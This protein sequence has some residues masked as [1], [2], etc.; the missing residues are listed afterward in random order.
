MF[1]Q[2]I[3]NR[4]LWD[5]GSIACTNQSAIMRRCLDRVYKP[6]GN[7]ETVAESRVQTNRQLWDD[8]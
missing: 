8:R 3:P 6:I 5:D 7:Y 4:Q 2:F 1:N